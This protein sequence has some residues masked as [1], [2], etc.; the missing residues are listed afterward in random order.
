MATPGKMNSSEQHPEVALCA[1]CEGQI[2]VAVKLKFMNVYVDDN[3]ISRDSKVGRARR[4]TA[5]AAVAA[6]AASV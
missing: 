2:G 5:C 6:G 4:P 3:S 1:T